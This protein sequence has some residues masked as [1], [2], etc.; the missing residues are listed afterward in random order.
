MGSASH[1]AEH[2]V[3]VALVQCEIVAPSAGIAATEEHG[4]NI[5]ERFGL[6]AVR[7]PRCYACI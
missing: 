2:C 7:A 6:V 5:R 4:R 1:V 3:H